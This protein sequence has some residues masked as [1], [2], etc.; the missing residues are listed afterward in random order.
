VCEIERDQ[1]GGS[2]DMITP[3]LPLLFRDSAVPVAD[4]LADG[5]EDVIA[6]VFVRGYDSVF[7]LVA[8]IEDAR[9]GLVSLGAV[10]E[11]VQGVPVHYGTCHHGR[12][13]AREGE[14]SF[15]IGGLVGADVVRADG[16]DLDELAWAL[17]KH[18]SSPAFGLFAGDF[19]AKLAVGYGVSGDVG[20]FYLVDLENE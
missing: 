1:A 4:V 3:E 17:V 8:A 20:V 19:P 6:A 5:G 2:T 18:R 15:A 7:V 12:T 9:E 13:S 16:D 10:A 11:G 14:G